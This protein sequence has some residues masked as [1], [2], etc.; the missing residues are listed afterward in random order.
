MRLV[1]KLFLFAARGNSNILMQ[2]IPGV[3]NASADALSHLQ[4]SRFRQLVPHADPDPTSI[5]IEAWRI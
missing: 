2:H 1:R 5:S 3:S 4:L